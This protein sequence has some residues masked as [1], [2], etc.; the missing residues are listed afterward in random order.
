MCVDYR[1]LEKDMIKNSHPLSVIEDIFDQLHGAKGLSKIDLWGRYYQI[2][3]DEESIKL[4][5][6]RLRYGHFE[7]LALP[8]GLANAPAT[9]MSNMRDIFCNYLDMFIIVFFNDVVIYSRTY[10]ARID[11]VR[12]TWSIFRRVKFY[13]N[14]ST[15]CF[16]NPSIA[17]LGNITFSNGISVESELLRTYTTGAPQK[18]KQ[19]KYSLDQSITSEDSFLATLQ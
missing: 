19:C 10:E 1:R 11:Y 3:L 5:A 17:Y 12:K 6:F 15:N 16:G 9:F 13:A 2:Q 4:I 14:L 7:F 18:V 8:F